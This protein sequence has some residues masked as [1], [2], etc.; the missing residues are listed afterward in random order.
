MRDTL[1]L[2]KHD[3]SDGPGAPYYCP[4]CAMISGALHYYPKLRHQVDVRYVDFPRPRPDVIALIGEA[5][6]GC[7]VLVLGD[8]APMSVEDLTIASFN[9]RRFVSGAK[10]IGN[11]FSKVYGTGKPP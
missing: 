5:N 11:Y 1:F 2:L 4:E 9:G 7:P 6:Q 8:D 10:E 3:F